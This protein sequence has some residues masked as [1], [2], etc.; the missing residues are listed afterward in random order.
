MILSAAALKVLPLLAAFVVGAF[1]W[2][3]YVGCNTALVGACKDRISDTLLLKLFNKRR[4]LDD[5]ADRTE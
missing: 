1:I 5:I 3:R 4:R 2:W